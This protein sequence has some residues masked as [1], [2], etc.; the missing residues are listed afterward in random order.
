V[1][2]EGYRTVTLPQ[3]LADDVQAPIRTVMAD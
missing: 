1:R 2:L 3:P